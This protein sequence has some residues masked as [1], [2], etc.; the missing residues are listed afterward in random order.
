LFPT[1][2]QTP[3]KGLLHTC[4]WQFEILTNCE[5]SIMKGE[6]NLQKGRDEVL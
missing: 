2:F 1:F 5:F 6:M 3:S 4:K